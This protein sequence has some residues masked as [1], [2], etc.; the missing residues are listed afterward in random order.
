[1][2]Q[3]CCNTAGCIV[4][5]SSKPSWVRTCHETTILTTY[6]ER[7][8]TLQPSYVE[9]CQAVR[10][11]SGLNATPP[12]FDRNSLVLICR[13]RRQSSANNLAVLFTLLGRSLM[14]IKN[15]SGSCV[16]ICQAVQQISGLN[17]T[18]PLFDRN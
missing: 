2:V 14:Y 8:T 12:L 13:Y 18:P 7:Q 6:V 11:T 17:A 15:S 4:V 16:E 10:Q 1:V 3:H 5:A 9:I